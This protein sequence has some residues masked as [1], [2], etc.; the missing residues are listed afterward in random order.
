MSLKK[1]LIIDDNPVVVRLNQSL[2]RAEGYESEVAKDGNEG[3][4]K[5]Q[6]LNPD[7]IL[8]DLIL[9]GMHGFEVCKAIKSN[10]ATKHI[11][12][13]IITG[14]G[15]EKIAEEEPD[16]A[17]DGYLAKPYGIKELHAA[18]VRIFGQ[19]AQGETS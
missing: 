7:V 5:S 10:P 3:V 6:T 13:I 1:A 16:I 15:L 18:L 11:P 4:A 9:P 14:S 17:A 19:T 8:L 12:I 2:L